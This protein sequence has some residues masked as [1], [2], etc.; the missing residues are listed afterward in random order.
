MGKSQMYYV[1]Q[2]N[3]GQKEHV[4]CDYTPVKCKKATKLVCDDA[5]QKSSY[6]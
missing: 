2:K 4:L 1:G 3:L 6:L 5:S